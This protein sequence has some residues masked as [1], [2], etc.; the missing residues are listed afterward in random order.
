MIKC[1]KVFEC[2]LLL[3][4]LIFDVKNCPLEDNLTIVLADKVEK[5]IEDDKVLDE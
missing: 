2:A 1:K 4:S 3:I 5:N